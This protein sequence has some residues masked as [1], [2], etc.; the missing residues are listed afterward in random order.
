MA[1]KKVLVLLALAV[2]L[3]LQQSDA[4]LVKSRQH[5]RRTVETP[6]QG[7]NEDALKVYV[8][9]RSS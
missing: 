8:V 4:R 6:G 2:A 9:A 5:M 7:V 3:V 1:S